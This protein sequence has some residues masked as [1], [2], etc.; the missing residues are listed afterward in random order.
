MLFIIM[1]SFYPNNLFHFFIAIYINT[2]YFYNYKNLDKKNIIREI[3]VFSLELKQ[4]LLLQ[5][6]WTDQLGEF[7]SQC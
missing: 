6:S 4:M 1:Q 3:R 5:K 7:V 2:N